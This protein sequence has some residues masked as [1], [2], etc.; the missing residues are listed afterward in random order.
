MRY[1]AVAATVLFQV[2]CENLYQFDNFL[3][4]ALKDHI[5]WI[6]LAP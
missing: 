3:I 5:S 6:W 2:S 4:H 1:R